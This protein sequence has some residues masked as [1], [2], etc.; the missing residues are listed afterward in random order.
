MVVAV[1]GSTSSLRGDLKVASSVA[2]PNVAHGNTTS[3]DLFFFPGKLNE[4]VQSTENDS[5][6]STRTEYHI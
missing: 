6:L 4:G 1:C 3:P 2:G 5:S